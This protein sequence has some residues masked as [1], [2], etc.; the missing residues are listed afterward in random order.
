MG[1]PRS[2]RTRRW[3]RRRDE[4]LDAA[5]RVFAEK[6]LGAATLEDV[7]ARV[8]LRRASLAYYFRDKDELY[9]ACFTRIVRDGARGAR[10]MPK[11]GDLTNQ[12]L[13][14]LQHFIRRQA[15]TA[16]TRAK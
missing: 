9:E 8:E 3:Q 1:Q 12:E 10:G 16:L 14:A 4:I 6:G 13:T 2:R 5:E 11:Y 7:A 15:E